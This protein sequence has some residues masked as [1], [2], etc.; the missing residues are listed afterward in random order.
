MTRSPL[1]RPISGYLDKTRLDQLALDPDWAPARRPA[2]VVIPL[3]RNPVLEEA[4]RSAL[5]VL[6]LAQAE[7]RKTV[8]APVAL[9]RNWSAA[10]VDAAVALAYCADA[11]MFESIKRGI[12]ILAEGAETDWYSDG[13]DA[14]LAEAAQ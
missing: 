9:R 3:R 6:R 8:P 11:E 14:A 5:E 2:A 7:Y 4:N 1:D 13:W 10:I 12:G